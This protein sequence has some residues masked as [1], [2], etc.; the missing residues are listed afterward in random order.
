MSSIDSRVRIDFQGRV[1]VGFWSD[2]PS[3]RRRAGTSW[4]AHETEVVRKEEPSN[5]DPFVTNV[6]REMVG[7][8][9][10]CQN[11]F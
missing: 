2:I 7:T 3:T 11:N 5:R 10:F 9:L 4:G 8:G 6:R 1:P